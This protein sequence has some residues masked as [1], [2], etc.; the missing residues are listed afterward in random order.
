M[1][2]DVDGHRCADPALRLAALHAL[3]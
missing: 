1:R 2:C 3:R